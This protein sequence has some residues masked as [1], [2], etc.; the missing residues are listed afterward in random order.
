MNNQYILHHS[1]RYK[2]YVYTYMCVASHVHPQP[3]LHLHFHLQHSSHDA[4]ETR[5]AGTEVEWRSY[6]LQ[7]IGVS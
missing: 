2:C 7:L 4:L 6:S 3:V 5:S 1:Y